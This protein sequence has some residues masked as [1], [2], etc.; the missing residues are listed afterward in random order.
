MNMSRKL[1]VVKAIY[2]RIKTEKCI[3]FRRRYGQKKNMVISISVPLRPI[4]MSAFLNCIIA[5]LLDFMTIDFSI[6]SFIK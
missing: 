6:F 3:S 2:Q 4:G 1:N 5:S